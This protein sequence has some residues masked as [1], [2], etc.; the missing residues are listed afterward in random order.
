MRLRDRIVQGRGHLLITLLA[1]LE[2]EESVQ[3]VVSQ[4]DQLMTYLRDFGARAIAPGIQILLI[5]IGSLLV[6]RLVRSVVRNTVDRFMTRAENRERELTQKANTLAHVI[7][8]AGRMVVVI[9]AGMMVLS[10]LG[11]DIA[12][13]LASAGIV[14]VAI[15]LGAQSLI[16]DVIGGFFVLLE[17]QY[18]VGDVIQVGDLS[19]VVEQLSLRR[20]ALRSLNGAFIVIPNGDIRTVT[21]F[22]KGWSRALVE[23]GVSYDED[24]DRVLEVLNGVIDGL[25]EDPV[26]GDVL[27]GPAEITGVEALEAHQVKVR[28]LA[29]TQPMEQWRVQRELRRRIMEAFREAGI[30]APYPRN[31]TIFRPTGGLDLEATAAGQAPDPRRGAD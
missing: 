10:K 1:V 17:D 14:G 2:I 9:V 6:L 7:E 30:G 5:V 4:T 19:G 23:V 8:S 26:I 16:K 3:E 22:T 28:I 25:E 18:A 21:N 11:M 29:K 20:T 27:L 15:G 24:L 13:L 31:V 12:P